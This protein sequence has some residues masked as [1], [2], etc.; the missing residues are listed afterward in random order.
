MA[1]LSAAALSMSDVFTDDGMGDGGT[2]G[3]FCMILLSTSLSL[4]EFL[5]NNSIDEE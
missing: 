4:S 5:V 2:A 1:F 3:V